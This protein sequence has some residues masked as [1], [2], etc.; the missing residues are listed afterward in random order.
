MLTI[1]KCNIITIKLHYETMR[2]EKGFIVVDREVDV[3]MLKHNI[4][5]TRKKLNIL[6]NQNRIEITKEI[7]DISRELDALIN[8]Y[9]WTCH[10]SL[11]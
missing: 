1:C 5:K 8:E 11:W 4:E 10:R 6:V 7:L 3:E 9:Y 2:I